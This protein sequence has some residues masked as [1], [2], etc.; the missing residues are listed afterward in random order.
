MV[1]EGKEPLSFILKT[2]VLLLTAGCASAKR[3]PSHDP[4]NYQVTFKARSHWMTKSRLE[5]MVRERGQGC[6]SDSKGTVFV[7]EN[8]VES[9]GLS[10][11]KSYILVYTIKNRNR[12]AFGVPDGF[13]M[14]TTAVVEIPPG[15]SARFQDEVEFDDGD[16]GVS[17][18]RLDP[19]KSRI[20]W[21][22]SAGSGCA[23]R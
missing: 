13:Q 21:K 22:S 8:A 16:W 17:H 1:E 14:K 20:E 2:L 19:D 3:Y 23:D 6:D 7:A 9:F 18:F 15:N 4:S 11:G 10:P 12:L 5:V